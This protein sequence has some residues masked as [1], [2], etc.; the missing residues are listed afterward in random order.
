MG[1]CTREVH[2]SFRGQDE[3]EKDEDNEDKHQNEDDDN[4]YKNNDD[5]NDN[6]KGERKLQ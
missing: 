5:N 3:N 1:K 2:Y 6:W 4:D